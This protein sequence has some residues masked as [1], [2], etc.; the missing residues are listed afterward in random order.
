[1]ENKLHLFETAWEVLYKLISVKKK[2]KKIYQKKKK[3][4]K[5]ILFHKMLKTRTFI[6][7]L[8]VGELPD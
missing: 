5:E 2:V 8:R 7:E 1:M 4:K 3:K 6:N